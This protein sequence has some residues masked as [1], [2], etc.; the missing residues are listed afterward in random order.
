MRRSRAVI[1]FSVTCVAVIVNISACSEDAAGQSVKYWQDRE[2]N[3]VRT[4]NGSDCNTDTT[5]PVTLSQSVSSKETGIKVSGWGG[6]S[7]TLDFESRAG[8]LLNV[9]AG[10]TTPGNER[11]GLL[12]GELSV[13]LGE[14]VTLSTGDFNKGQIEETSITKID[15]LTACFKKS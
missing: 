10:D 11:Q 1:L 8:T 15:F 5:Y 6:N 4:P 12:G 14:S 9:I 13:D 7:V 3:T 2:Q